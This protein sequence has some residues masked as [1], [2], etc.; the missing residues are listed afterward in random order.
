M[1]QFGPI[2]DSI[3]NG[4]KVINEFIRIIQADHG[5]LGHISCNTA[6]YP[7]QPNH[8]EVEID[9]HLIKKLHMSSETLLKSRLSPYN[10]YTICSL[11]I[12]ILK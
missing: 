4:N 11:I 1:L 8:I 2:A 12:D 5:S 10:T 9:E 6:Y 7:R 3:I